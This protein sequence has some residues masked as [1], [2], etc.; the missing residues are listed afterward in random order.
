MHRPAARIAFAALL[1][2]ALL[3]APAATLCAS[4]CVQPAGAVV[5]ATSCCGC[6][7]SFSRPAPID[8]T[9]IPSR[10]AP[11]A[12]PAP[13]SPSLVGGLVWAAMPPLP[14]LAPLPAAP[15]PPFPRRL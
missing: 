3:I 10:R 9:A 11:L 6:D 12:A 13:D 14:A 2:A 8:R 7:G 1:A 15:P 5:G 4:C